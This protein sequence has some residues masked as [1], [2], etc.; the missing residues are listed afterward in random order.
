VL[1]S[2]PRMLDA[3]ELLGTTLV[4][5]GRMPEGITALSEVLK[6]DPNHAS[7]HTALV[8]V[9]TLERRLDLAR[10]HAELAAAGNPGQG[11]ELLAQLMLDL[12]DPAQAAEF[13]RKSLAA[14][15]ERVMSHFVLGLV[16]QREGRYEQALT[17]YRLAEEFKARRRQ[18]IVRNLHANMADCLA[19][20]GREAE[21]EREFLKEIETIPASR[22]ARVGLALLY[23]SQGRDAAARQVLT[24]LVAAERPAT[25]DTYW[26]VLRTLLVLGDTDAAREWASRAQSLYPSDPRFRLRPGASS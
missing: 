13:A 22:E 1:E 26:T 5:M 18:T 7:T 19:R 17:S 2:N 8:K 10:A 25:A 23:R 9:Y 14:D 4:R 16:A 21:A 24:D 6:I 15:R 20:L 12:R 3:W 11:Y